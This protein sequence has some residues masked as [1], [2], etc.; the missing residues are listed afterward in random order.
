VIP[1]VDPDPSK[2]REILAITYARAPIA[3]AFAVLG[4]KTLYRDTVI[5]VVGK[6]GFKGPTHGWGNF[7]Q[8]I[9]RTALLW[10]WVLQRE[11]LGKA[12]L[13]IWTPVSV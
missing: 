9:Q 12:D 2:D 11:M 8:I 6:C 5:L 13:Q 4:G 10:M 1:D 7:V 3:I